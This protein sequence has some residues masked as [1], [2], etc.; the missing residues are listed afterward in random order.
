[1]CPS[2]RSHAA[3][4]PGPAA[5]LEPIQDKPFGQG[6]GGGFCDVVECVILLNFFKILLIKISI[7]LGRVVSFI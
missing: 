4:P 5:L 1:M 3:N 6:F 7:E 2:L